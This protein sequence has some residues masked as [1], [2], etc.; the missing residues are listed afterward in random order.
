MLKKKMQPLGEHQ[1]G[2]NPMA[3][4]G[5]KLAQKRGLVDGVAS[6]LNTFSLWELIYPLGYAPGLAHNR[7]LYHNI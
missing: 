1:R 7:V 3:G 4:E 6:P 5:A 2:G